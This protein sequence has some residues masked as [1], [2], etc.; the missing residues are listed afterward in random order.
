VATEQGER[1]AAFVKLAKGYAAGEE[2]KSS[3][4]RGG[5]TFQEFAERWTK[6]DLAKEFPAHLKEKRTASD[7]KYRLK[8]WVYPVLGPVPL[9]SF[10]LDHYDGMMRSL[11]TADLSAASRRQIAQVIRRV[12]RLA[13]YPARIIEVNP[14]PSGA[15]PQKGV[16][17]AR[18]YL[19]PSEDRALLACKAVPL[20]H[21]LLYGFLTREGMRTSEAT[22]LRWELLDLE[23]GTVSVETQNKTDDYRMRPIDRHVAE[24]L[25]AWRSQSPKR[26]PADLVFVDPKGHP[27][28]ADRLA[29]RLRDHLKLAEVSRRELFAASAT[30]LRLRAHDLRATFVTLALANGRS[31]T[32]V[33]DR[34][35]HHSSGQI[36]GYRRAAR[37]A[38]E[39]Q[40]GWLDPLDGA[41]PELARKGSTASGTGSS[42]SRGVPGGRG[43]NPNRAAKRR[44]AP[45]RSVRNEFRFRRRKAWGFKSLLVHSGSDFVV[46][47]SLRGATSDPRETALGAMRG[48]SIDVRREHD[49]ACSDAGACRASRLTDRRTSSYRFSRPR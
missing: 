22:A 37:T 46:L 29:E 23:R 40:L 3:A 42:G 44:L 17:K 45:S 28:D 35:G 13:T 18:S 8:K 47:A 48:N 11:Q 19:Y 27:L 49:V 16:E 1:L 15:L 4:K 10:T 24:A 6:G 34:T 26:K 31:E 20:A 43:R 21:R 32:W 25:L 9:V 14:I 12:L 7:D 30:R 38:K 5:L 36:A 2:I 39:L 33:S 41:I